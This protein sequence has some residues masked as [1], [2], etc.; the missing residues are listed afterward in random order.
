MKKFKVGDKVRRIAYG[1]VHPH[2]GM[3]IGD[4]DVVTA[5]TRNGLTL[6]KFNEGHDPDCF[7]LIAGV[8]EPQEFKKGDKVR[9][10][11]EPPSVY[12][13]PG[14][15]YTVAE[16]TSRETVNQIHLEEVRQL[17]FDKRYFELV[18]DAAEDPHTLVHVKVE[19]VIEFQIDGPKGKVTDALERL[20][21]LI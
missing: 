2:R 6:E 19:G 13:K 21:G 4:V 3:K 1:C 8:K 16:D 11:E 7:E 9:R 5:V 17:T 18:E 15:V 20:K 14:C 10:K 12:L